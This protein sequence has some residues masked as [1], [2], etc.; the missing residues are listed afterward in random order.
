MDMPLRKPA[1]KLA[2][3]PSPK[4]AFMNSLAGEFNLNDSAPLHL[5]LQVSNG[6][7][8]LIREHY[9]NANEPLPSERLLADTLGV[10]RVTARKAINALAAK[11]MIVRRHGSGNYITAILEQPL[12]RLV[13]FSD[14]IR[15]RGFVPKSQWIHRFIGAASSDE[16]LSLGLSP[17]AQVA[18]LERVRLSD[19]LPFAYEASA[20]PVSIVPHPEDVAE[21][22]YAYLSERG[23][24]PVR[25]LQHIRASNATAEQ[26]K[27][28]E[29]SEGTALLFITRIAYVE[30]GRAI[31]IT[32]SWCRSDRYDFVAELRR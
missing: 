24:L 27:L 3:D 14:E 30:D 17:G 1:S 31:E 7:E 11:G 21:S 22:L 25:A 8:R 23:T 20:L 5:Y 28:L 10:S 9:F 4:N 32:H 2:A 29:I 18:R 12:N 6:L 16:I 13:N 26:A 19:G 15:Q